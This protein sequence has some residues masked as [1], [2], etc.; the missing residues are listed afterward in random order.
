[1][2]ASH[3]FSIRAVGVFSDL[4][5]GDVVLPPRLLVPAEHIQRL[6]AQVMHL[7]I[8]GVVLEV[9]RPLER[10]D[11]VVELSGGRRRTRGVALRGRVARQQLQHLFEL[12]AGLVELALQQI[13]VRL[14]AQPIDVRRRQP[15]YSNHH[16][17]PHHSGFRVLQRSCL[18]GT[19]DST[20]FLTGAR[21]AVT[22]T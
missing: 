9:V 11:G 16:P 12:V 2:R 17:A 4:E 20:A 3:S 6:A 1:M 15:Q 22:A 14:L 8:A 13:V 19:L 21:A 5:L 7:G 10:G 18:R